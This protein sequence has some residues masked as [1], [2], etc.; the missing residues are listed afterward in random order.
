MRRVDRDLNVK[1]VLGWHEGEKERQKKIFKVGR[2][3]EAFLHK[4]FMLK[5][6]EFFMIE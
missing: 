3:N 2:E 6:F 5:K 4:Y 1:V